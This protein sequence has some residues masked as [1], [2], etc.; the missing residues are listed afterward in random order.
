ML[1]EQQQCLASGMNGFIAKPL[2]YGRML[3]TLIQHLPASRPRDPAPTDVQPSAEE[4]TLFAPDQ[5]L[6]LVRGKPQRLR[7][8][9]DMIDSFIANGI[10]PIEQGRALLQQGDHEAARRLFHT[11]KGSVGNLGGKAMWDAAQAVE[12]AIRDGD[13]GRIDEL[14]QQATDCLQR[15]VAAARDWVDRHPEYRQIP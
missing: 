3:D 9:L 15:T 6:R 14:L 1:S 11:L 7:D 12:T 5:L 10:A 13:L 4:L 8:L 2:D